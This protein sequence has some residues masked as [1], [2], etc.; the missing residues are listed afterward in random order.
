MNRPEELDKCLGSLATSLAAP[1]EVLVSDDSREPAM[2]GKNRD[3]VGK[4]PAARYLPGPRRGLSA[5]RN[6]CL[7]QVTGDLVAFID[8]DVILDA[9]FLKLGP[10]YYDE[11][12]RSLG[13]IKVLLTGNEIRPE[14][15]AYPSRLNFLGFY[16]G[17]PPLGEAPDAIGINTTI[18][19]KTLFDEAR[20]DENIRFGT[21]ERDISMHALH[22]GY[23]IVYRQEL[24]NYHFPS[25][26]NRDLYNHW[27]VSSQ[28]YFGLKRY[29]IYDRSL[30]KF[31]FFNLYALA[32]AVGSRLKVFK[33]KES[34][35]A[36]RAFFEAWRLFLQP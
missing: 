36:A 18:F 33:F 14:G 4:Y 8:D 23:R 29:W 35:L 34:V 19:P 22:L 26:V 32:N 2:Q 28:I 31:A 27:V 17:E 6:N 21:E 15:R 25:P 9:S 24:T 11:A 12:C 30:S 10:E 3:V 16:T 20:F 13:T 7:N 1:H 5:N